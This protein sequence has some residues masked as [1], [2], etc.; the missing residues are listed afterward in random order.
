MDFK[1]H[2]Y[3]E[4]TIK[5]LVANPKMF[6]CLDMGMG[7]TVSTLTAIN[8]LMFNTFE[9]N[10]VLIIAPKRVAQ[11]TWSDEVLKWNHLKHLRVSKIIGDLKSRVLGLKTD[12]DIYTINREQVSWLV[13]YCLENK[14][15]WDFDCVVIDESSSFKNPSSVRF[16]ALKKVA[17]ITSHLFLLTG[18]PT[19]NGLL[20]IWAQVYLLDKGKRLGKNITTYRRTFFYP[21]RTGGNGVVFK[22]GLR[23]G[24][25]EM[26]YNLLGD[27]MMSLK[28]KDYLCLPNRIDNYIKLEM[29]PK[30]RKMYDEFEKEYILEFKNSDKVIEAN[31]AG[32][33]CGKLLQLAN[34]RVYDEDKNV[35]DIH[36]IK[37]DALKEIIEDNEGKP[38]LVF[39]YFKHDFEILMEELKS[40]N[41]RTLESEKDFR[42]WN[43]KKIRILLAHPAS[44][45]H[46]LNLQSGGNIIV[47]YGLTWSLEL[48]QQANAR[49]YRQGQTESVIIHHL[50]MKD[51]IDEDVIERLSKK[52]K[53]QDDLINAIKERMNKY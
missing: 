25:E 29:P 1:P 20:D 15:T 21:E 30:V 3:Q 22:Y 12:A 53:T 5:K 36:R 18:T 10:K 34:G 6:V 13:E 33:V 23:D 17:D 42:D 47:W 28:A 2:D 45:G 43:D 16:R 44:M 52:E 14:L 24:S 37:L 40:L 8:Y 9:I 4:L 32:V 51:T 27:I 39:Y 19:P 50:L 48:Y 35:I 26:I 41:P 11:F 46:G 38:I 31:S 7:K 49:L